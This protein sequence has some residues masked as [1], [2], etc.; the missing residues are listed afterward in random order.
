L[1]VDLMGRLPGHPDLLE[2]DGVLP[3]DLGLAM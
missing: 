3:A 1:K 2:A